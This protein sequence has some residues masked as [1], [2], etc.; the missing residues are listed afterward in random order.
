MSRFLEFVNTRHGFNFKDYWSLHDWS[1]K[2]LGAF[3]SSIWE[4]CEVM[5]T[6]YGSSYEEGRNFWESQFF[7]ESRLNFAENL[8]MR[9][10][11]SDVAV[12]GVDEF[13]KTINLT[14]LELRNQ[15]EAVASALRILGVQSGDRVVA[16]SSNTVETIVFALGALSIGAIVSTCSPDFAS[17]AVIDRFGQ[18][19]PK[20]LLA[21]P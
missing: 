16:W 19:Q 18:I 11:D 6:R 7:P 15:V 8:I 14:R 20:V 17:K 21:N 9:G 1:T 3:W 10:K 4:F 2:D 12:T 13:G 5:G